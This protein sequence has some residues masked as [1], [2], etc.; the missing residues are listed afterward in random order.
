MTGD[1]IKNPTPS[2]TGLE[3]TPEIAKAKS[4]KRKRETMKDNRLKTIAENR[5]R[6]SGRQ[7]PKSDVENRHKVLTDTIDDLERQLKTLNEKVPENEVDETA[8][9]E[10]YVSYGAYAKSVILR[11]ENI[12]RSLDDIRETQ[13]ELDLLLKTAPVEE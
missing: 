12:Q 6:E 5:K 4:D 7:L 1:T 10:G 3:V 9:K 11:K 8:T 13:Q 2:P